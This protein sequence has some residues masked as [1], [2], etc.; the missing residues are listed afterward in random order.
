[1]TA[2]EKALALLDG[3]AA[4]EQAIGVGRAMSPRAR[5]H[6]AEWRVDRCYCA[7]CGWQITIDV[8]YALRD[9]TRTYHPTCAA[10]LD[11]QR[12]EMR[13]GCDR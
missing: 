3:G 11:K 5:S 4:R 10:R 7:G 2:M 12:A 9:K 13:A 1:M 6:W 8:E